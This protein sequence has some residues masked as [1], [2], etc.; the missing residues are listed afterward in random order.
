MDVVYPVRPGESND[1]LRYSLRS[2]EVNFPKADKVWVVGFK[3]SWLRG[4]EFID[5]ND[6]PNGH[7]NVYRNVLKAMRHPGVSDDVVVFNDDFFVLDP[8]A[9]V[10]TLY[11]GTMD[12]HL[13]LP[14]LRVKGNNWWK[15]SLTITKVCLQAVGVSKPLS[16]ELHVPMPCKK[17]LMRE[18]LERFADVTPDNPPQWRTL[19]G[20]L[21]VTGA[22]QS[23][24]SKVFRTGRFPRPYLSTSDAVWRQF[25]RRIMAM[26]PDPSRFEG[27]PAA[28]RRRA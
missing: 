19:Y 27:K 7:A 9:E 16:Y 28:V 4:V 26:F 8:I 21:H 14:R 24:D 15:D 10:Q 3:P 22:V 20:N 1:E 2:L 18:T 23:Q 6:G 25:S 11:R 17:G 12:E 13:S 5:G